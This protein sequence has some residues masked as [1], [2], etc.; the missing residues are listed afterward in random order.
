MIIDLTKDPKT[1][2]KDIIEKEGFLETL[3]YAMSVAKDVHG[4]CVKSYN[5]GLSSG[6]LMNS[7]K[8]SIM[9]LQEAIDKIEDYEKANFDI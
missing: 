5:K 4:D 1:T 2:I 8:F 6:I 3:Q 7:W 9:Q